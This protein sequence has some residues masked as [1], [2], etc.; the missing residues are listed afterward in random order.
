MVRPSNLVGHALDAGQDIFSTLIGRA[1]SNL[2]EK[3][4]LTSLAY[5]SFRPHTKSWNDGCEIVRKTRTTSWKRAWPKLA[6]EMSHH[7]EYD[8]IVIN[9]D[10]GPALDSIRAYS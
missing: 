10:V 5:L 8:Y 7:D 4:R 6:N 2:K 9:N 3:W 1:R